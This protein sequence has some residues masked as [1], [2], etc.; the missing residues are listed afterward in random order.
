[1]VGINIG[2]L[3]FKSKQL[4]YNYVK[5][6]IYDIGECDIF[7]DD[8]DNFNFLKNLVSFKCKDIDNIT[9]FKIFKTNISKNTLHLKLY[10]DTDELI[11]SWSDCARQHNKKKDPLSDIMRF[12]IIQDCIKFKHDNANVCNICKSKEDIHTDHVIPFYKLKTDFIKN[13]KHKIP[14]DFDNIKLWLYTFKIEDKAFMNDWID[15]HK[16]NAKF[17]LLC[18]KCNLQKGKRESH[19]IAV[20]KYDSDDKVKKNKLIIYTKK[21]IAHT[22]E[23]LKTLNETLKN[24]EDNDNTDDIQEG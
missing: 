19:M 17:Q 4:A 3:K 12:V 11:I 18:G 14:D 16:K 23:K 6:K 13:T 2:D 24:I 22:L 21:R 8:T 20:S 9:R 5:K 1:M 15:Y 10:I 7:P